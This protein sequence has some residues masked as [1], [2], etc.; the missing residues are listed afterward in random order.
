MELLPETDLILVV[1]DEAAVRRT[2][3]ALVRRLGHPVLLAGTAEQTLEVVTHHRLAGLILDLHLGAHSGLDLLSRIRERVPHLGVVMLTGDGRAPTAALCLQQGV[4]DYL[5]KPCDAGQLRQAIEHALEW[6]R[7]RMEQEETRR[8]LSEEVA[9]QAVALEEERS[10]LERLAAASLEAMVTALE[11]KDPYFPGHSVRVARLAASLASALGRSD[12]EVEQVRLA[13]RL[14]DLGMIAVSDRV[15]AR[16]TPLSD[17]EREQIREHPRHGYDLLAPWPHLGPVARFV[18]GHHERWDGKGYPDRLAGEEIPWGARVL[19]VAEVYDA[20]VCGRPYRPRISPA[21]ACDRIGSM[22]G[23][24][25]D[26]AVA[27]LLPQVAHQPAA[28]AS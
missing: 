22:A 12:E 5:V 19:A 13:G 24:A 9:A 16:A 4:V 27:A 14:H 2:I 23:A 15:V 3:G 21:E 1:D 8:W 11:A 6:R 20:L 28:L 25:L 26:P 7:E 18:R 17:T 10:K